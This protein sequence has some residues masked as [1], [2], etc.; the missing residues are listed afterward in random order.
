MLP[1][2]MVIPAL[3]KY[4]TT[5]MMPVQTIARSK[6]QR[7]LG[8]RQPG[9]FLSLLLRYLPSLLQRKDAL[10]SMCD[11]FLIFQRRLAIGACEYYKL[12]KHLRSLVLKYIIREYFEINNVPKNKQWN[13]TYKASTGYTALRG[14]LERHHEEE[15]LKAC[16][17]NGWKVLLPTWLKKEKATLDATLQEVHSNRVPFT[18]DEFLQHLVNWIIADDQVRIHLIYYCILTYISRSR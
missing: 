4:S 5:Q 10:L 15:Y 12:S 8:K 7:Q 6:P 13:A 17:E 1:M 16:Q 11:T 9:L 14:H 3:A 2:I 18:Q